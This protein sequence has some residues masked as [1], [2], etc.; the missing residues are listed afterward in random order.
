MA[1]SLPF[2]AALFT[3]SLL[4]P[5][6]LRYS[7]RLGLI[8]HPNE[9][10]K[11]HSVS[12]SR[13]G[14]IAIFASTVIAL[15]LST[16]DISY[17]TG[18]MAAGALIFVFGL[19]DDACNLNYWWKFGGQFGAA[20]L[21]MLGGVLITDIPLVTAGGLPEWVSY[22]VTFF[23]LVGVTN[24]VNLSDGLDGLAGGSTFLGLGVIAI[25]AYFTDDYTITILSVAI[26]G[27]IAGFLRFNTHPATIFMGDSGSQFIGFMAASLAVLATQQSSVSYNSALPLLILGLPILDTV[28]VMAVRIKNGKSP[29]VADSSH[30]HHRLV[31]LGMEKHEAVAVYYCLQLLLI[32]I[33]YTLRYQSDLVVISSYLAFCAA[34]IGGLVIAKNVILNPKAA[35]VQNVI[36]EQRNAF[37]RPIGDLYEGHTHLL[38]YLLLA[39]LGIGAVSSLYAT[40]DDQTSRLAYAIALLLL[41][42]YLLVAKRGHSQS[43]ILLRLNTS[44]AAAVVF[45]HASFVGLTSIWR[46]TLDISLLFTLAFLAL[47]I[48]ISR[49]SVYSLTTQDLLIVLILLFLQALPIEESAQ[50]LTMRI[51]IFVFII[52]FLITIGRPRRTLL[53]IGC[54]VGL[55]FVALT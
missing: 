38:S 23:F 37:F 29:F 52:E 1:H 33:A 50:Y 45:Y 42:I 28:Y 16:A 15:L 44:T 30:L 49:R 41:A 11:S 2:L 20:I 21:A 14:G 22:L 24:A 31:R 32:A 10:R 43:T 27:A 26:A 46:Y 6:L 51:T 3:C 18:L 9:E 54:L 36:D 55:F 12:I 7:V 53:N 25:L 19:I 34:L 4:I 5:V 39:T 17:I 35:K 13:A 47:C 48:R 8:D 40:V